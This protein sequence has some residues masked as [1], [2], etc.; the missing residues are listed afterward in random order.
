GGHVDAPHGRAV[1]ADDDA[2]LLL[3]AEAR[4]AGAGRE[5]EHQEAARPHR[6]TVGQA[7][8][9]VK[10]VVGSCHRW[11]IDAGSRMRFGWR[12]KPAHLFSAIAVP[13][14]AATASAQVAITTPQPSPAAS[15]EQTVGVTEMKI[16][17]HRPAVN[18]RKI[19]GGLVPYGE[20]WR[21]GANENTT[22]SFSTPVRLDG[23]TL[24][25]GTYGL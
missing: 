22:I 7:A 23:K 17:Y 20:V 13:L 18:G 15:V 5:R 8:T 21:A 3:L 4:W 1:R 25:A 12:M 14:G 19:W 2:R 11:P 6:R 9:G 24:P 16:V 10:A